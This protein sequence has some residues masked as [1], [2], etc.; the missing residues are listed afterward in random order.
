MLGNNPKLVE[1]WDELNTGMM[2]LLVG[3]PF[4]DK[5][6]HQGMLLNEDFGS[7]RG[8]DGQTLETKFFQIVPTPSGGQ[9][10]AKA[11]AIT[12]YAVTRRKIYRLPDGFDENA[13]QF[14]AD[15]PKE[16]VRVLQKR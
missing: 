5:G 2:V 13:K 3:C 1:S 8:S 10:K 16:L 12:P 14:S 4:C 11:F 7:V 6:S 15:R 9:H